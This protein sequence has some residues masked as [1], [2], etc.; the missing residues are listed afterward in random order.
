MS[1]RQE[2]GDFDAPERTAT[3]PRR[4]P[5]WPRVTPPLGLAA[6]AAALLLA[7]RPQPADA[8]I[9]FPAESLQK[10]CQ[11][12]DAIAVLRVEKVNKEKNGIVYSKARD[13][14]G[15]YPSPNKQFG[16]TFTHVLQDSV[17]PDWHRQDI[18]NQDEHREHILDWA[19]EGKTAVIF[20]RGGEQAVCVGRYWYTLRGNPPP[21]EHW[22]QGGGGDSRFL[23]LFC[24]DADRLAD[25]VADV[26]AGK[27]VKV[28][29]MDGRDPKAVSAHTAPVTEAAADAK[30]MHY[31]NGP[32]VLEPWSTCRGDAARTGAPDGR[33]GP[34]RPKVL[35]AYQGDEQFVAAP[36]PGDRALYVC[37][38]GAFNT[39]ALHALA[40]DAAGD[41]QVLWS[42]RA[43]LLKR[44]VVAAPALT[45]G[46]LIVGDGMHQTEGAVLRCLRAGDGF[47]LWE[48]P[49][50]GDLVHLEGT[51][52]VV[53][54]KVYAACGGGGVV[55]V[56]L[57]RVMFE[58]KER[59]LDEVEDALEKQW[60][61]LLAK[62]EENKKK[63]PM[64]A[65]PPSEDMLP[66]PKPKWRWQQGKGQWHVDAPL[67]ATESRVVAASAYLDD[68]KVG[69]R[70][71]FGLESGHGGDGKPVW[72]I[73]LGLNP[74]AGA[75]VGG[76]TPSNP[77]VF[78][79][80]SS[81]RFDPKAVA[82]A[83]GEV[84]AADFFT[85]KEKW[86]KEVPGG[87]LSAVAV[88]DDL[89]VFTATDGKV[90]VWKA[91]TGDEVWSYDAKAPLFAGAAVAR[92]VVYTADLKGVVH[93]ISLADGKAL[94]TLD[95]AADPAVKAGGMVYGTPVLHGGRLYV[96]T[97]NLSGDAPRPAG[98]VVCIGEK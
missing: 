15:N 83:R 34:A 69:E 46:K 91:A 36:V 52:A 86:R 5:L 67:A 66:K 14:K 55:C 88:T 19:A 72:K 98:V 25:A 89:A 84:L 42:R 97:C 56:E 61:A 68:E 35:W 7:A 80:C 95:L 78:V 11:M 73:R 13:L 82:D 96:T 26:L 3:M 39:A 27:E 8:F 17:N 64:F 74:W 54:G 33:S 76:G 40:L 63:D 85:G 10:M 47:P 12:A 16:D 75:T 50:E 60:K 24:G 20:Q 21:K 38:L 37:G 2:T 93:A 22:V 49:L 1:H 92:G 31:F 65:G 41:K 53:D 44:P 32:C 23:Q 51:P 79:G 9:D 4:K 71:L 77:L 57:T 58:G 70:A 48:L 43:P 94:W 90:R 28:P 81:I 62:Y 6:A 87:V 18:N 29:H 59:N 30:V 45:G